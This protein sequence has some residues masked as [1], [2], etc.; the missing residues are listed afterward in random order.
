MV[1]HGLKNVKSALVRGL[2]SSPQIGVCALEGHGGEAVRSRRDEHIDRGRLSEF[3]TGHCCGLYGWMGDVILLV[4][5]FELLSSAAERMGRK[6][7]KQSKLEAQRS[8]TA[9]R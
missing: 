7:T 3:L 1:E 5:R 6:L 9:T 4:M 2:L 8:A